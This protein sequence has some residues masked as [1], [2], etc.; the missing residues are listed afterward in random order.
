[1]TKKRQLQPLKNQLKLFKSK[2][3]INLI[4]KTVFRCTVFGIACTSMS[5]T[6]GSELI[7]FQ[8]KSFNPKVLCTD[9]AR[10]QALAVK[11]LKVKKVALLTPYTEEL[12]EANVEM[13]RNSANVQ[14][15]NKASMGLSK[16]TLTSAVS[17][18][19]I[20]EWVQTINCTEAEAIII[21]KSFN[22]LLSH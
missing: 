14:V 8:L 15:V 11:T 19:T 16:D 4:F 13:L 22:K 21:G 9:M 2:L 10:A 17:A 12:T 3:S 20:A 18:E 6:L 1:L 7:D 5:Y